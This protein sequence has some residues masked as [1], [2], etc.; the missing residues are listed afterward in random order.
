MKF[1][2]FLIPLSALA[3]V[4][5]PAAAGGTNPSSTGGT[6][7][8]TQGT[9]SGASGSLPFT[10]LSLVLIVIVGLALLATGILLR[11]RGSSTS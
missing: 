1:L 9:V 5:V 10:G 2:R 3:L 11:R 8:G 6:A 4:L 7:A